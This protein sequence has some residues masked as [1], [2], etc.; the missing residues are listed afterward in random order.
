MAKSRRSFLKAGLGAAHFGPMAAGRAVDRA[1]SPRRGGCGLALGTYGLQSMPLPEAIRLVAAT[2]YDAVEICALPGTTGS[3]SQLATDDR[4]DLRR[5]L[6]DCGL[7]LCG[8]MAD[9]R[10]KR[11]EAEHRAQLAELYHLIQLGHDLSPDHTPVLQSVLG[12][13]DW[14][15]SREFFRDR[16]ADWVQV[17]ADAKGILSVKPHRHH[18]MS[19]PGEALWLIAQLGAP[20][21]LGMTFD[22]SHYAFH[23]PAIPLEM[24]VRQAL[25]ETN[26]VAVKDAVQAGDSIRFALVGEGGQWKPADLVA[27]F[28]DGG[29]RGDF[30]CEVS[31]QIWKA[32][33]YDP[34]A[35][36]QTCFENMK[37]AF[38]RAGVARR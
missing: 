24:A 17:T 3:P 10:P 30:C 6:S 28:H 15:E 31:S 16:I 4:K 21:R 11:V 1:A 9:L 36:T 8:I 35:A 20:D 29:Y 32:P 2:G 12:G 34:I 14:V 18:A 25:P 38:A 5:L 13:T 7:R 22:Y 19:L 23:D 27:A 33:T 37:D 26:Y